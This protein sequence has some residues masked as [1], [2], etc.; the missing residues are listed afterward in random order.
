LTISR[1]VIVWSAISS[2]GAK[3]TSISCCDG[4]TSWCEYSTG[5]PIASSAWIVSCRSSVAA[6]SV[7]IAK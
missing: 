1:Y 4:P 2:A 6:S 5:M 7:V 3:R